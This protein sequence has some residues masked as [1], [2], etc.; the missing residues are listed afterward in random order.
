MMPILALMLTAWLE[1][2]VVVGAKY[3]PDA[4]TGNTVVAVARVSG[5]AV[6]NVSIKQ[7][8]AAFAQSARSAL[9]GWRFRAGEKGDIL[10]V[11]HFRTPQLF[12][13]G[14]S[15]QTIE[16]KDVS[17]GMPY[18]RT[19]VETVYPPDSLGE[20]SVIMLLEVN[21]DGTVAKARVV[22]G[23]GDL[24]APSV[25]AVRKWKF[26]PAR[27]GSGRTSKTYAYAVCIFRRPILAR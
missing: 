17:A 5:G 6:D 7:G 4:V 23:L 9:A 19:I 1:A 2:V 15:A 14:S 3:P 13:V 24:T 16:Q 12:P 8:D 21:P 11:F 20:G 10:V 25:A 18:P 26:T 22:Q 27:T